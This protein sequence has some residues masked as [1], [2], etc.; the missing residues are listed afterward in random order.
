VKG[1]DSKCFHHPVMD[2]NTIRKANE[3]LKKLETCPIASCVHK[4]CQ[5]HNPECSFEKF[6]DE[7][8]YI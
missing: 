2:A 1:R 8:R 4:A 6:Y 3:D 7:L 5:S